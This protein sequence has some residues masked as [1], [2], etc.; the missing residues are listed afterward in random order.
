MFIEIT[1]LNFIE[2]TLLSRGLDVEVH[3]RKVLADHGLDYFLRRVILLALCVHSCLDL[4][5]VSLCNSNVISTCKHAGTI[6]GKQHSSISIS[7]HLCL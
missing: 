6:Y 7:I 5:D 2:R 3:V 4:G 1:C